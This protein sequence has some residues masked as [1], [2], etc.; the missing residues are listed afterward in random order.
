M[1][2]EL[3]EPSTS[4]PAKV[5]KTKKDRKKLIMVLLA[6]L[7]VVALA[8]AGLLY[9]QF[10]QK[11]DQLAKK[12]IEVLS[13]ER[14]LVESSDKTDEKIKTSTTG[15][16]D[17]LPIIIFSPGGLFST[18]EKTELANKMLNPY[19]AWHT[20]E[21]DSVVSIHVQQ[22][23]S[24]SASQYSV[25]AIYRNSVYEGFLFGTI[26][27]ASQD[28]WTPTCLDACTFSTSFRATYPEVVAA[29]EL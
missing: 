12:G 25:D 11:K 9:W 10:S 26:D 22:N 2:D 5:P 8:G 3:K 19:K 7:L 29:T 13:L 4:E 16:T 15:G 24:I 17:D 1:V 21:G 18:G 6:T 14:K 27:A 20:D 23:S 28:W